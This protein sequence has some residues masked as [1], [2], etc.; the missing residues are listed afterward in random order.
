[1]SEL[2]DELQVKGEKKN[3]KKFAGR[4]GGTPCTNKERAGENAEDHLI[5]IGGKYKNA[6]TV[7]EGNVIVTRER[8]VKPFD[9]HG[10][11]NVVFL[12]GKAK[13]QS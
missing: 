8:C 1:M 7:R 11:L 4:N 6:K 2:V 10:G 5:R 13:G 9:A 3:E 12:F